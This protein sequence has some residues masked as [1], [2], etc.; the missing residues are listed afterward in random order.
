M[1]TI[2]NNAPNWTAKIEAWAK[3]ILEQ[4]VEAGISPAP[5]VELINYNTEQQQI[6]LLAL[7]LNGF[8]SEGLSTFTTFGLAQAGYGAVELTLTLI[9]E[10]HSEW[11][12]Q[13]LDLIDANREE[14]TFKV[15]QLFARKSPLV[16]DAGF[17]AWVVGPES[18]LDNCLT[19]YPLFPTELALLKEVGYLKFKGA[20]GEAIN[21]PRR[22]P[23]RE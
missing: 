7:A 19:I 9:N 6:P 21:D 13:L 15:G 5:Q 10:V 8:P 12:V 20:V 23:L 4:I 2:E 22:K 18:L 3:L 17:T 14:A 1:L 16:P 11:P